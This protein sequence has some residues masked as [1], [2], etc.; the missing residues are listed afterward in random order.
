MNL[1]HKIIATLASS[2]VAVSAI[3][4]LYNQEA[5]YKASVDEEFKAQGE[6]V[7][8]FDNTLLNYLKSCKDT[9]LNKYNLLFSNLQFEA[10]EKFHQFFQK[11]DLLD[12]ATFPYFVSSNATNQ[13]FETSKELP[14]S[15]DCFEI[16][17]IKPDF[18]EP[19][20]KNLQE[21]NLKTDNFYCATS[22]DKAYLG[23]KI[24]NVNDKNYVYLQAVEKDNFYKET[25]IKS[26]IKNLDL[27]SV[28]GGAHYDIVV[29]DKNYKALISSTTETRVSDRIALLSE[30]I[31]K[32]AQTSENNLATATVA[33][34]K[35]KLYTV[36]YLKDFD[37]FVVLSSLKGDV[38]KPSIIFNFLI[39]L[40]PLLAFGGIGYFSITLFDRFTKK[41]TKI[42]NNIDVMAANVLVTPAK[43]DEITSQLDL[44]KFNT[45]K[46]KNVVSS[47]NHLGRSICENVATKI[48]GIEKSVKERVQKAQVDA[49][50]RLISKT[51]KDLMPDGTD[52]PNS[53]F[54]DIASFIIPS[55][56]EPSDFYDVFRVDKDNIG[57][58]FGSCNQP[59]LVATNAINLCTSF[60]RKSFIED[61]M[62]PGDT[63]TKLNHILM[64]KEIHDFNITLF[65]MILSEYTGNFIFTKAGIR[66]PLQI[67]L[68][69][70]SI[71]EGDYTEKELG[72]DKSVTYLNSKGKI[73]YKDFLVFV[74]RGIQ[75][76]VDFDGQPFTQ[77]MIN[78][79]CV[80]NCDTTAADLLIALYKKN[81][82]FC[83]GVEN[84]LDVSGIV[85]RRNENNKEFDDEDKAKEQI[86]APEKVTEKTADTATTDENSELDTETI[87]KTLSSSAPAAL[88]NTYNDTYNAEGV[89]DNASIANIA[90]DNAP[91][92]TPSSLQ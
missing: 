70:A 38:V 65:A 56:L 62:L 8:L 48:D 33:A 6:F 61:Q 57:I 28:I 25:T 27:V 54:L 85:I 5:V 59:G 87:A 60:I 88:K 71:I 82:K 30:D 11:Q 67:H 39:F 43:M 91:T 92:H 83:E 86:K 20:L 10:L 23:Y 74:G 12:F 73:T 35:D 53:K 77:E 15:A 89:Q 42:S 7:K 68:H 79:I 40:L 66:S 44:S 2:F 13:L 46:L 75:D 84:K 47:L 63:L 32:E 72:A 17:K 90:S 24:E 16:L 80:T 26:A 58:I 29:L 55:K 14:T 31:L 3:L 4:C 78:E 41:L 50:N 51:H 76:S 52:M 19:L 1:K 21:N 9:E 34:D 81:K 45:D 36:S 37:V 69:K 49:V 18:K 64:Q 22:N